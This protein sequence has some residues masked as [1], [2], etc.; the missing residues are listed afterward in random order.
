MQYPQRPQGRHAGAAGEEAVGSATVD[1]PQGG[2][3]V[4]A[5][6]L[7]DAVRVAERGIHAQFRHDADVGA[8]PVA[9][10]GLGEVL[11]VG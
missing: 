4:V 8:V 5:A 6:Q 3:C 7:V 10:T 2:Q 9:I 1:L 11:R